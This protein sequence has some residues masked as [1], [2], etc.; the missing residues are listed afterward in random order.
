[1]S[2]VI[3]EKVRWDTRCS[4]LSTSGDGCVRGP[5][6][7]YELGLVD[8]HK[9]HAF[10]HPC[11]PDASQLGRTLEVAALDCGMIY[12][13]GGMHVA[14]VSVVSGDGKEVFDECVKMGEGVHT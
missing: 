10:I 13:T 14:R 8:L 7:F 11:P 5:R 1:M 6:A 4:T 3:G 9:R 2:L 12:P